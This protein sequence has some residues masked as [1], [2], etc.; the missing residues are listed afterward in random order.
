MTTWGDVH[1][2]AMD[3]SDRAL[4]H[5]RRGEHDDAKRFFQR[6]LELELE[7]LNLMGEVEEPIYSTMYRSCA[8]L[9]LDCKEYRLAEKV[10]SKALAGDPPEFL[11]WELREVVEKA[12]FHTHLRLDGVVLSEDE[13][14]MSVSGGFVGDGYALYEDWMPRL[15]AVSRLIQRVWD[16]N[17]GQ[18]HDELSATDGTSTSKP[19]LA[20][21][22]IRTG[23]VA[24]TIKIGF[25]DQ[26]SLPGFLGAETVIDETLNIVEAVAL[27]DEE[28][29]A[30]AIPDE[31]Y[32]RNFVN[33][34]RNIAPDGKRVTQVG[35]TS[36]IAGNERRVPLRRTRSELT[37][38]KPKSAEAQQVTITGRLLYADGRKEKNQ[39]IRIIEDDGTPHVIKVQP[40]MMDDIVRPLWNEIVTAVSTVKG[41]T[42][43]LEAIERA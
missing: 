23:S 12:N 7:A 21:S 19:I 38:P 28:R 31:T 3:L 34:V 27:S 2:E 20:L 1:S 15:N 29:L 25:P 6:A 17:L 4:K 37:A 16:H 13:F 35:F 24:V 22:P 5:K 32:R 14:Q 43:T 30:T 10:A 11:V 8:T 42:T 26:S 18:P 36:T 41:K 33:L 40:G 39:S 9:A